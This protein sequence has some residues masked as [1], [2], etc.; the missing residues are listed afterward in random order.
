MKANVCEPHLV[1]VVVFL[2]KE[3]FRKF[4]LK[5]KKKPIFFIDID[6]SKLN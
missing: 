3:N 2:V 6:F 4:N 1:V 5:K